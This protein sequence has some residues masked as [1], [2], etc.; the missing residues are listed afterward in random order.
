MN[1]RWSLEEEILLANIRLEVHKSRDI[2]NE[3]SFWNEVTQRF[4]HQTDG[5]H[6]S[7]NMISG[8]WNRINL[9]CRKFDAIYKDLQR[10]SQDN[11]RLTS[12]MNIFSRTLWWERVPISTC[13]VHSEKHVGIG[14]R[15]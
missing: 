11:D 14:H 5:E 1:T 12:A 13:V 10:T 2:V 6:R 15:R 7:K 3:R 9:E 8:K 4:N